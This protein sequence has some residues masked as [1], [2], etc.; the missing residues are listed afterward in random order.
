VFKARE[1][2]FCKRSLDEEDDR[3]NG[4][5]VGEGRCGSI[6]GRMPGGGV[7]ENRSSS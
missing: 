1:R 6:H 7:G 2:R 3:A 4:L 5:S